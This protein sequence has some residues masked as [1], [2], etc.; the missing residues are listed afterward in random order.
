VSEAFACSH[1]WHA[2]DYDNHGDASLDEKF[3]SAV[4]IISSFV[5]EGTENDISSFTRY[6]QDHFD[7]AGHVFFGFEDVFY[8]TLISA[9]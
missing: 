7:W 8:K 9:I 6:A 2:G 5:G 4:S 3:V 1:L